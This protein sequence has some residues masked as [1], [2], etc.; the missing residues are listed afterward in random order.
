MVQSRTERCFIQVNNYSRT[1]TFTSLVRRPTWSGSHILVFSVWLLELWVWVLP[2]TLPFQLEIQKLEYYPDIGFFSQVHG[3]KLTKQE[4]FVSKRSTPRIAASMLCSQGHALRV[5][6]P[7]PQLGLL[8]FKDILS[9]K[10]Q[11]HLFHVENKQT[12]K[13]NRGILIFEYLWNFVAKW[14]YPLLKKRTFS[15]SK[16]VKTE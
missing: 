15:F 11:G 7:S 12:R 8:Y 3:K 1:A 14:Y 16:L 13:R 5:F 9:S 4:N 6:S 10:S 2:H